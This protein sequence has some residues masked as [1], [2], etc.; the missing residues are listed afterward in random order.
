M[1][2]HSDDEK[3]T[4]TTQDLFLGGMGLSGNTTL[5][6]NAE[7]NEEKI[8]K[9]YCQIIESSDNSKSIEPKKNKLKIKIEELIH[10]YQSAKLIRTLDKLSFVFSLARILLEAFILGRFPCYFPIY[11]SIALVTVVFF[12]FVYYRYMR[13]HYFLLDFCYWANLS[14]I[15]Y[16]WVR[17][18]SEFLFIATYA[19]S[20]GPLLIA[21]PIFRNSMVLHSLDKLTSVFIHVTPALTMWSIRYNSCGSWPT[22]KITPSMIEY[23]KDTY[24][25]YI[26]WA[27]VYYIIIFHLTF[28]RCNKKKN[29]TMFAY[30]LENKGGF[31]YNLTGFMGESMR[32]ILFMLVHMI[33]SV[34]TLLISYFCLYSQ[35]LHIIF[36]F[37][38]V[39]ATFWAAAT[40]YMEIFSK[41]YELKLKNLENIKKSLNESNKKS[42]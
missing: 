39:I 9:K 22:A 27:V 19:F 7:N 32:S 1:S 18:D 8:E 23:F 21:V 31:F 6:D 12:R 14:I 33:F 29:S 20:L 5:E 10:K 11:Y 16:L 30:L 24:L 26:I 28:D 34:I 3:E 36:V 42:D 4:I 40:Y 13:W 38:A 37:I 17:P 2:S 15:Y 25:L 41:N 35:A